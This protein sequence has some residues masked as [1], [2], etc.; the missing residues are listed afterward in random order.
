MVFK[1]LLVAYDGSEFSREALKTAVANAPLWDATVHA[2]YVVNPRYYASTIVDPQIGVVEPRS[3]HW[4]QMLE[5]EAEE[6][7]E[8]ATQ[9]AS[10]GGVT[11]VPHVVIGD[12]RDEILDTAKEIG[13]DLIILGS[14]GKGRTKRFLLGSVSTSVV[15][16]SPI[17]TLVTHASHGT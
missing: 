1:T 4:L 16:E 6:M 9:I 10:D 3:K 7:L 15:T 2:V 13:A 11:I 5:R 8:E 17:A 14:A 12:P